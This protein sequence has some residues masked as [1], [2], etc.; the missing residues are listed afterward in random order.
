MDLNRPQWVMCTFFS[1]TASEET[2]ICRVRKLDKMPWLPS[3]FALIQV[4]VQPCLEALFSEPESLWFGSHIS[5]SKTLAG[6][7]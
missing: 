3:G 6:L 1:H 2:N 5:L 7:D 4:V